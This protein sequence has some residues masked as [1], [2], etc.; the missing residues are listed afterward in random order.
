MV[1]PVREGFGPKNAG[2]IAMVVRCYAEASARAVLV[3][4]GA[5]SGPTYQGIAFR[6]LAGRSPWRYSLLVINALRKLAPKFVE[7][8]QQPRLAMILA[9]VLPKSRILLFLHNDPL[10]MRGLRS[11]K[12]RRRGL[13]RLHRVI[14]VSDYLRQRYLTDMPGENG[15]LAVLHNPIGLDDLPKPP[16]ARRNK[17][18]YAGRIVENKGVADFIEACRQVLPD[19]P[20]WTARIIGGDRFGPKSPETPFFRAARDAAKAANIGFDGPQPHDFV[21]KHMADSAIIVVPSRWPEPF[22][23]TALEAM[24]SGAAL[25]AARAG[26]LPE[27][28]GNAAWYFEPGDIK[29]LANAIRDVALDARLRNNLVKAG[30]VRARLF[31]T[32]VIAEKLEAL[33]EPIPAL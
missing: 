4:G 17:I 7:V 25:I 28:A 20:G 21:L 27:V 12:A 6:G 10:S 32:P 3:L 18:L 16:E 1:L 14:C 2:A 15:K 19:M 30:L 23:L 11:V 22:G 13:H 9:R 31:D 33:R 24:A 8:H 29:A 26:G 5:Q